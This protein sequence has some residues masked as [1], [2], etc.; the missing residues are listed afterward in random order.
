MKITIKN[1]IYL[2]YESEKEKDELR[3]F[4]SEE[5]TFIDPNTNNSNIYAK[6]QPAAKIVCY[7][8]DVQNKCFEIPRGRFKLLDKI[9]LNNIVKINGFEDQRAEG[10]NQ[11]IKC[12]FNLR[13]EIQESAFNAY[14]NNQAKIGMINLGCGLGK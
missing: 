13:D 3:R 1:K 5:L 11:N 8:H 2:Y 14:L 9:V 10:I 4:L 12:N 6:Y 7:Y